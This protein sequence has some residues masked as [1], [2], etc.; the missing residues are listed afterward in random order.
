MSKV[1]GVVSVLQTMGCE[2]GSGGGVRRAATAQV[3]DRARTGWK[4]RELARARRRRG[5]GDV[6]GGA[7]LG[8]RRAA[9]EVRWARVP[10]VSGVA[11]ACHREPDVVELIAMWDYIPAPSI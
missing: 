8:R 3:M 1:S 11:V 4:E 10:P 7:P 9:V 5:G 6:A 2:R